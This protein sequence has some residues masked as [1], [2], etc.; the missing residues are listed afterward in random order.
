MRKT[1]NILLVVILGLQFNSLPIIWGGYYMFAHHYFVSHCEN[2]KSPTCQ[3]KCQA[4]KL[5]GKSE[6]SNSQ[7][8][9]AGGDVQQVQP[10]VVSTVFAVAILSSKNVL[11]SANLVVVPLA[12]TR[13]STFHPPKIG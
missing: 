13:N 8:S 10:V 1:A 7:E 6:S 9:T 4:R 5:V 2:S 11:A 3:G 12:G